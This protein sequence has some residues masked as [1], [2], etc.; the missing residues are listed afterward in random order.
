MGNRISVVKEN[1]TMNLGGF[2]PGLLI[3]LIYFALYWL[4]ILKN[5]AV[6]RNK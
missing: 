5:V 3:F 6:K 1:L 2:F 4:F